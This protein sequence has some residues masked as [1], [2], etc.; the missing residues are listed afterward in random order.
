MAPIETPTA[1][2]DVRLEDCPEPSC[3]GTGGTPVAEGCVNA[4][5]LV[6]DAATA[7]EAS[8]VTDPEL[9]GIDEA[10]VAGPEFNEVG[11]GGNVTVL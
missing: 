4:E 9:V 6:A 7:S 3:A 11:Y 10:L 2:A 1:C 8:A 5:V